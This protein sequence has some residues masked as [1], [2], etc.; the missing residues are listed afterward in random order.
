MIRHLCSPSLPLPLLR[1]QSIKYKRLTTSTYLTLHVTGR[2]K[3]F[4][5]SICLAPKF[6]TIFYASVQYGTSSGENPV[7]RSDLFLLCFVFVG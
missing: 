2:N 4:K 7:L 1:M 5:A 6:Q 3:G